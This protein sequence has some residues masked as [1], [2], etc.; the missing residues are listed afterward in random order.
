[1]NSK[2]EYVAEVAGI[3]P[4]SLAKI[5]IMIEIKERDEELTNEVKRLGLLYDRYK[6]LEMRVGDIFVLY[7]TRGGN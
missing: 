3:V 4:D 1:M 2:F 6:Q 7:I 5:G